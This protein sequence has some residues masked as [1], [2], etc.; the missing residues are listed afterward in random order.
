M[1]KTILKTGYQAPTEVKQADVNI[2]GLSELDKINLMKK[3]EMD[4]KLRDFNNKT[5]FTY[6]LYQDGVLQPDQ[7]KKVREAIRIDREHDDELTN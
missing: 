5:Q 2:E 3:L 1:I 6:G 7:D 4:N